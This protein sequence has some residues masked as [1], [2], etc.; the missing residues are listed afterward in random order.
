MSLVAQQCYYDNFGVLRRGN[1]VRN[2]E[3]ELRLILEAE[4]RETAMAKLFEKA[5]IDAFETDESLKKKRKEKKK[6]KKDEE[7]AMTF[8][9]EWR[10]LH[11]GWLHHWLAFVH[12]N[13]QRNAPGPVRNEDLLY[14]D[15][16]HNW[17]GKPKLIF[18]GKE[19]ISEARG[20]YRYIRPST[21]KIICQLYPGSGPEIEAVGPPFHMDTWIV[22]ARFMKI[23]QV[24]QEANDTPIQ[25]QNEETRPSALNDF[26][27]T[28]VGGNIHQLSPNQEEHQQQFV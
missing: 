27:A 24:A 13:K 10:V 4:L 11:A 22:D 26:T 8:A 14:L 25:Q 18:A 1:D 20:H 16:E 2:R 23:I 28:N 21:W 5:P 3:E 12:Y 7:E 6:E 15:D 17:R 9:E 19:A